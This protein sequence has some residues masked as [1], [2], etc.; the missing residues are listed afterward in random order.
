MRIREAREADAGAMA[1]LCG[2]LGYA[3]TQSEVLGRMRAIATRSDHAVLVVEEN[4]A[5]RGWIHVFGAHHIESDACADIG[6][7]V[8]AEGGRSRG[9]GAALLAAAEAWAG[10]RGYRRMRV[11]SNIVRERAHR[12]YERYGYAHTKQSFVFTKALVDR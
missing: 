11:R 4:D 5:V 2:Q 9:L 3:S 12:F 7:L 6:G 8:V 1:E 10:M